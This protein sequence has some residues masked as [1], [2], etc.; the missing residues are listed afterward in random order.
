ME[1]TVDN[2]KK[3]DIVEFVRQHPDVL[4]CMEGFG[5]CDILAIM[6]VTGVNELDLAKEAIRRQS[7][8]K[9][10]ATVILIED[11]QFLFEN[12][13]LSGDKTNG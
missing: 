8:I 2:T 5:M 10:I 3:N 12:L 4:I 1:I 9:K 13:D 11:I 6:T 7:G